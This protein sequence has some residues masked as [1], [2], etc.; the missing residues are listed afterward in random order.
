MLDYQTKIK[1]KPILKFSKTGAYPV[2][3]RACSSVGSKA[4]LLTGLVNGYVAIFWTPQ[5]LPGFRIWPGR[6]YKKPSLS[7][8]KQR[9]MAIR[10][11]WYEECSGLDGPPFFIELKVSS[12]SKFNLEKKRSAKNQFLSFKPEKKKFE[13]QMS[14]LK[15]NKILLQ[16]KFLL[17]SINTFFL[18]LNSF[19]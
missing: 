16:Q 3:V 18:T 2:W 1:E 11:G 19:Q 12:Y 13:T 6:W 15:A 9:V 4:I 7:D 8:V 5:P 14:A 17:W 10:W